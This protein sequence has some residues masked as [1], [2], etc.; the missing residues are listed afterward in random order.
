M[1][2][3]DGQT[4]FL[5]SAVLIGLAI[6]I[7]IVVIPTNRPG[8]AEGAA[9]QKSKLTLGDIPFDGQRSYEMLQRICGLGSRM[10]GSPGMLKQQELLRDHFQQQGG[11]VE[12]QRFSVRH[13]R[14]GSAV[15]MANLIVRW[16]PER[17]ERILLCAHYDTRP[18]PDRDPD[19]RKRR[20]L[21]VG[22]NDGASGVALLAELGNLM[23]QLNSKYGVDFVLFD[24]EELVYEDD[25][26]P[27]FLGSRYFSQ[28][29]VANPPAHRYKAAVLLDMVA[30]T[31]LQIYQERHSLRWRDSRPLVKDIWKKAAELGVVEFVPRRGYEI[32]DDHLMLHDIAKIPAC[33]IIDF[34]YGRPGSRDSFWHTTE[35]TP[36]KCSALSLAKV[37]WVVSEW[38]KQ[39]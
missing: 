25:R 4:V 28:D 16:H 14:N 38:L 36:D 3:P 34:D 17:K 9:S 12:F 19:P 15:P 39:L 35:D 23:P 11:Q 18:F 24:G 33:D 22:A 1:K 30:D 21:F 13:P 8:E 27:Y 7:A 26:D 37:G 10:S 29:Y 2:R 20:G 5:G 32:R 6:L 31:D